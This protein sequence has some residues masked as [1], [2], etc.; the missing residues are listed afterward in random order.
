[1]GRGSA[2]PHWKGEGALLAGEPIVIDMVPRSKKERYYSDMTR[3]VLHGTP[4]NELKEMYRAV[5]DSQSAAINKIKAGVTGAY[6]HNIVCDVLEGQGFE[7]A[8]ARAK[9][10]R[11]ALFIQPGMGSGLTSMK[12][13][14]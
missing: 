8:E 14:V 3:T 1:V 10:S 13:P 7:T 11:K 9:S 4:T 5:L 6:I 12:D 2:D